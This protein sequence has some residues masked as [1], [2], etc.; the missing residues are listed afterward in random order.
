MAEYTREEVLDQARV[1]A[2]MLAK[3]EEIER[4]TEVETK[5]NESET[6]QFHVSKIKALQKQA[7]N[8]QAYDKKEQLTKVDEQIDKLQDDLDGL[9]IVQEFKETQ[10]TV[11]NILQLVSGTIARAVTNHVIEATDGD[12][13]TGET[14][15]EKKNAPSCQG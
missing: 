8:L 5:I 15:S 11:N 6:V 9:P 14:G 3:T 7:V 4:F 12:V 1:L 10:V 2:D 13:M